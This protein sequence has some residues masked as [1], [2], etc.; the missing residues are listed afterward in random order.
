MGRSQTKGIYQSQ[1]G[2][3]EVDARYRGHRIRK[4]GLE[5]QEE[6]CDFLLTRKAEIRGQTTAGMRP[7]VLLAK[8]AARY[9]LEKEGTPSAAAA[10]Y[11]LEPVVALL[12][13]LTLDQLDDDAIAPF[14]A[15]RKAYGWASKTIN[16]SIECIQAICNRAAKKWRFENRMTWIAAAPHFTRLSLTDQ[17][18]PRPLTWAEQ[19]AL[20]QNATEYLRKLILFDL[21]TGVRRRVL[22]NLSWSWEIQLELRPGLKVSIFV[23]PREF[24]KGRKR[25]RIIVCNSVAQQ[26]ID[27]Q[28]GL[29][30]ERVFT[31][32]K[33]PPKWARLNSGPHPLGWEMPP[34]QHRPVGERFDHVWNKARKA[35]GLGDLHFHDLRHTVGMRLRAKGVPER[36]Q[37]EILW[38]Y[39]GSMPD[40]YAVAQ[41]REIYDALE[42]IKEP[43]IE[44]ESLNLHALIREIRMRALPQ[45]SPSDIQAA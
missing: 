20:L 14:I 44:G 37:N 4:R 13:S 36:T 30:P 18:P 5:N 29:H 34:L 39:S 3:F 7:K 32:A 24:V 11:A 43:D 22:P 17:R 12:G 45:N 42:S 15:D 25:E 21:N 28:R 40:H 2:T 16:N 27:G 33:Q 41:L 9:L 10:S 35:A 23:V 1:D 26:I 19:E 8:A 6:A 38:H 31:R